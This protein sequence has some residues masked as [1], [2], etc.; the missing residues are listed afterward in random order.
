MQ[1]YNNTLQHYTLQE[2]NTGCRS[3]SR[4]SY[5]EQ[6]YITTL[7]LQHYTLQGTD[8]WLSQKPDLNLVLPIGAIRKQALYP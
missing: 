4:C 5:K 6:Q 8:T 7:P 1:Q 2:I 3:T